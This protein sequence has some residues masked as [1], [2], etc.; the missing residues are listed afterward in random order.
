MLAWIIASQLMA[1]MLL[2]HFGV[3][4]YVVR[5]ISPMRILGVCLLVA[6]AVLVQRF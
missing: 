3:L 1:G 5:E 2:D 6:G 4:G